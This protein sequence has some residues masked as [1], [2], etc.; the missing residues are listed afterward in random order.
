MYFSTLGQE[1]PRMSKLGLLNQAAQA[2]LS[3]QKMGSSP[4]CLRSQ[5]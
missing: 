5:T 3:T 1:M 4:C 2:E